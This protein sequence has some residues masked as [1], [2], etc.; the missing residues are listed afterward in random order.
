MN[1]EEKKEPGKE[2]GSGAKVAA[3]IVL[4]LTFFPFGLAFIALCRWL[5]TL[6]FP[7]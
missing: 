7:G 2:P 1:D 5:W 3:L 4:I 6:A